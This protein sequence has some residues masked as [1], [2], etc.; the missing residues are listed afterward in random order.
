M[1][2]ITPGKSNKLQLS[3]RNIMTDGERGSDFDN[4]N[5]TGKHNIV[6]IFSE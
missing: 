5:N 4:R 2:K 1:E 3:P 6:T